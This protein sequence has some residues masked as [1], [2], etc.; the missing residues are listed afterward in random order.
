[1]WKFSRRF[2]CL[3][4]VISPDVFGA[5]ITGEIKALRSQVAALLSRIDELE[6]KQ[7]K[8]DAAIL[9]VKKVEDLPKPQA[10]FVSSGGD[11]VKLTVS[12]QVNRIAHYMDNG[13]NSQWA[14][15][16]NQVSSSRL[17]L[18][19]TGE[20]N[21]SLTAGG[22][23][24]FEISTDPADS[25]D[26]GD[27]SVPT[28]F[29]ERKVEVFLDHKNLGKLTLGKGSVAGDSTS[30]VDYSST[31]AVHYSQIDDIGGGIRFFNTVT[32]SKDARTVGQAFDSMDGGSR[33]DRIRYDSLKF[34]GFQVST[35]H[36]NRD[37]S[38]IALRYAFEKFKWKGGAAAAFTSFPFI[39][40]TRRGAKMYNGSVSVLTPIGFSVT[41]AMG[42]KKY[43]D[44][45]RKDAGF[46]WL[47]LAQD[48][49]L[50]SFGKTALSVD[51]AFTRAGADAPAFGLAD[52]LV[53]NT[54][55]Y[56][57]YGFFVV[58]HLEKAATELYVG[59]RKHELTRA[60]AHFKSVI[61]AFL[62][63]RIK[64]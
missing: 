41:G 9:S 62:G 13:Q 22:T 11:K 40:A 6:A 59:I 43:G 23:I 14:H 31:T 33:Q 61:S 30:E 42:L 57:S 10:P 45:G 49:T 58:Q 2:I 18:T 55:R 3:L 20:I 16:D 15:Q 51:Y 46:W 36:A 44:Q 25:F 39:G 4:L 52:F 48:L 5:S 24:E 29:R 38:D 27:S 12:G 50:F 56:N 53:I 54:E 63:A 37:I 21:P 19:G 35:S 28:K 7:A 17:N 26:V 1:V 47:K 64:F 60:H 8:T 32:N 34:W